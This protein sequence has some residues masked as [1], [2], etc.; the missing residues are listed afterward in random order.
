MKALSVVDVLKHALTRPGQTW[1][2]VLQF[3]PTADEI[4]DVSRISQDI[5]W[6]PKLGRGVETL[7]RDLRQRGLAVVAC[8]DE[9][10]ALGLKVALRGSRLSGHVCK[11]RRASLQADVR[12]RCGIYATPPALT[13]YLARSVHRLLQTKLGWS[14][15]LADPRVRLLDPAAGSMNFLRASWRLAL[16]A[17]WH[18]GEGG[19]GSEQG[20]FVRNH[21]LPHFLGIELTPEA[22]ARGVASLRRFLRVYGREPAAEE[23]L[24]AVLG[25]ALGPAAA[26]LDFPANVVLG[27]PPW[28][29]RSEKPGPWIADL[30]ADYYGLDGVLLGEKNP[31]WLQDDAVR[32]LRLAQ[33]KLEQTGEGIVALLLPHNGLDAPTFRGLRASLLTSFEEIYAYDL[34]GNQRKREEN[35]DGGPDE[36]VFRGVAQGTAVFLLVKK[37]GLPKRVLRADLQGSRRE[38][39]AALAGTHVGTTPWQEV[40]PRGPFYLFFPQE[41]ERLEREY[42]RGLRLPEIFPLVSTGVITGD[43]GLVVAFSPRALVERL[44]ALPPEDPR[45]DAAQRK[46]LDRETDWPQRIASFLVRPFDRRF[47]LYAHDFLERSRQKV[48]THLERGDNVALL[49]SRQSRGEPGVFVTRWIAGHKAAS[50]Y[51]VSSVFPLYLYPKEEGASEAGP[52][53]PNLA[54]DLLA[55]L[56]E[57]YGE[58]PSPEEILGY[59]YA[60]LYDPTYRERYKTLLRRDFPRIPFARERVTFTRLAALGTELLG[61][62]LL[63][64]RRLAVPPV[65]V[66]GDPTRRLGSGRRTLLRYEP[67]KSRLYVNDSGL[68]FS[69]ISPEVYRYGIGGYDVLAGWLV[70]RGGRVLLPEEILTFRRLASALTLTLEVQEKIAEAGGGYGETS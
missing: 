23:P 61:L 24:P 6:L 10:E 54:L 21:L 9:G 67:K 17:D 5:P 11:G 41:E 36:N 51:D 18:R 43:D 35:P 8:G 50:A 28:R 16:E 19:E 59:V 25:D 42:C 63:A 47:L 49:A 2:L 46:A 33:W 64:D 30:V 62:H 60:V 7:F 45:L 15:G 26:V 31:K 39:L 44:R 56:A 68:G 53:V 34:H 38:K 20:D 48:M 66:V 27:N 32:F 70:P 1:H 57:R 55:S 22:Q 69:E 4:E 37:P 52:R 40:E 58:A 65:G 3:V 13:G 12:G 14:A 29:G